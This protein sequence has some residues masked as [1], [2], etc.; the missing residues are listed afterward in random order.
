VRALSIGALLVIGCASGAP[1]RPS[2]SGATVTAT[3][4]AAGEAT[5]LPAI[6]LR[7]LAG[8]A[9]R[10][11]L[12]AAGRPALVSLWATWCEACMSELEALGRLDQVARGDGASVIAVAVGEP[13]ERVAAFVRARGLGYAQLVDERFALADAL[14]QT[15]VPATLVLDRQGRV[16]FR[17]GAFDAA[18][19]AALHRVL[20]QPAVSTQAARAAA[21]TTTP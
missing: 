16:V 2:S 7:T 17:G 8:D 20:E 10:I 6:E 5:R 1:L 13:R 4:P 21:S 19:V 3:T 18:A 15:R 11:E 14:G 12:V 9:A